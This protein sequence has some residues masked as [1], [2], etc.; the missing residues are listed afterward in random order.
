MR[1][2]PQ[3]LK[4]LQARQVNDSNRRQRLSPLALRQ[5]LAK[6]RGKK[7]NHNFKA[8]CTHAIFR[9]IA[10]VMPPVMP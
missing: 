5:S 9:T 10:P 3:T 1:A 4:F 2:V 8:T 7:A 6:Q